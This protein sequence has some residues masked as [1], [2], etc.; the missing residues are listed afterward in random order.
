[1]LSHTPNRWLSLE[2]CISR[3]PSKYDALIRYFQSE[4]KTDEAKR[5]LKLL[6]AKEN[7]IYLK[8]VKIFIEKIDTKNVI[9]SGPI[10][11]FTIFE[12]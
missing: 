5:I 9:S 8:F 3:V 7:K 1:M 4:T 11:L 10:V 6:Q 12:R 2:A